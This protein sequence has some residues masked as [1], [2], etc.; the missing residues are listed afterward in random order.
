MSD[1]TRRRDA[2]GVSSER[3]RPEKPCAASTARRTSARLSV[4]TWAPQLATPT[5]SLGHVLS[6]VTIGERPDLAR[7]VFS[8]PDNWPAFMLEDPIGGVYYGRLAAVFPDFQLMGL[9]D[10]GTPAAKLQS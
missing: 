6:I 3:P 1:R 4:S 10:T 5:V 7:R 9:D 2:M 8:V